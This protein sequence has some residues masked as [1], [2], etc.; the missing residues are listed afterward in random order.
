MGEWGEREG[1][2]AWHRLGGNHGRNSKASGE[3]AGIPDGEGVLPG[4]I[5]LEEGL[6]RPQ[7]ILCQDSG[8]GGTRG[9]IG[10]IWTP[11]APSSVPALWQE[12]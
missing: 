3:E 5:F 12:W 9:S 10:C 4:G 2:G 1:S 8:W 7:G 11:T 6:H